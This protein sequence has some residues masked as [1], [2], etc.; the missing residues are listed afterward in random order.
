MSNGIKNL[1]ES[2]V[3]YAQYDVI[4][5]K[6]FYYRMI[7]LATK[8]AT[9]TK[10]KKSII[11]LY[12]H[13]LNELTRFVYLER[14]NITDL[15]IRVKTEVDVANNYFI[16][17][18][19]GIIKMIDIYNTV[20]VNLDTTNPA[21][22]IDKLTKVNHFRTPIMSLIKRITY[23]HISFKCRVQK[24]KNTTWT[25]KLPNKYIYDFL[26][27][28]G[29]TYLYRIFKELDLIISNRVVQICSR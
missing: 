16:K 22:S 7:Y 13:I 21:V 23:G 4:Y 11:T 6:Y 10:E 14:N 24:D 3:Y 20:S 18:R 25:D 27:K 1:P 28:K 2:Q 15:L 17:N 26:D 8:N 9:S 29:Y 5:L 19:D 12:K